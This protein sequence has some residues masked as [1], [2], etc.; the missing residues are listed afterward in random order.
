MQNIKRKKVTAIK[1]NP[2]WTMDRKA[3]VFHASQEVY[4]RAVMDGRR[5]VFVDECLFT[6]NTILLR[7]FMKTG[8]PITIR[9]D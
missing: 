7:T 9:D 6:R 8:R 3:E 2:A 5:V 1:N 4:R